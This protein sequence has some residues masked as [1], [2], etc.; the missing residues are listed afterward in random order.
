MQKIYENNGSCCLRA[1]I[2][3]R[4]DNSEEVHEYF[5]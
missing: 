1:M 5:S 4:T 2:M 3:N